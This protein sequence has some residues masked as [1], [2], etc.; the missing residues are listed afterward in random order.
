M[1]YWSSETFKKRAPKENIIE[2][3][4]E[5][6]VKSCAYELQIGEEAYVTS[7]NDGKK[8]L[9]DLRTQVVIPPGQFALL[10]TEEKIHIPKDAIGFISIKAGIKFR[11]LVNV[12]GF[13]VD[14]GFSGHLKFAVYNA[15]SEKIILSRGKK[16]F[17]L[18]LASLDQPTSDVYKGKHS[19]QDSITDEDIM[20]LQGEIASPGALN[21]R[22]QSAELKISIATTIIVTIGIASLVAIG[23]GIAVNKLSTTSVIKNNNYSNHSSAATAIKNKARK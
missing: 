10:L 5:V 20:Q 6:N 12:S 22:L 2:G 7:L 4:R 1:P 17:L 3:F 19:D 11:G 23:A 16:A 18:W 8:L 13:H 15:G 21:K 9:L 14:P